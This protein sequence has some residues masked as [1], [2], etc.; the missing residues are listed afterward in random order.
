MSTVIYIKQKLLKHTQLD[1]TLQQAINYKSKEAGN[2]PYIHT[3]TNNK[4]II[5]FCLQ[6][7]VLF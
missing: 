4:Q 3:H 6:L 5:M 1:I 2:H 7:N